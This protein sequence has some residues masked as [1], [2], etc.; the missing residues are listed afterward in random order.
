MLPNWPHSVDAVVKNVTQEFTPL[1]LIK[2]IVEL[3]VF[4]LAIKKYFKSRMDSEAAKIRQLGEDLESSNAQRRKLLDEMSELENEKRLILAA[5]PQQVLSKVRS[6]Y[7]SRNYSRVHAA[8]NDWF[9][10]DGEVISE[11][12]M[13]RAKWAIA[14]SAGD[15]R[16]D[17]LTAARAY[18]SAALTFSP[19]RQDSITL[20]AHT[21]QLLLQ[22]GG[23]T[24]PL[25]KVLEN[26]DER[27]K[28]Y[29]YNSGEVSK[30]QALIDRAAFCNQIGLHDISLQLLEVAVALLERNDG[31][32]HPRVL[33]TKVKLSQELV[34]VGRRPEAALIAAEVLRLCEAHPALGHTHPVTQSA[35]LTSL[36]AAHPLPN[37][38]LSSG[39]IWA[40]SGATEPD[41]RAII[42]RAT[43]LGSAESVPEIQRLNE[44][45]Q[46]K[47]TGS[48][49][50]AHS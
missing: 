33:D 1:F 36:V 46:R 48:A 7:S 40:P 31:S 30:A 34:S 32:N 9:N 27:L 13:W 47:P 20:T 38:T 42:S 37:G 11:L 41:V 18:A 6:D 49:S 26:L 29:F 23:T 22:A 19:G 44:K 43:G 15:L 14:H 5:S 8:V 50:D 2:N 21:D 17:A 16:L 3:G 24:A 28:S 35:R 12:L 4:F 39:F 45:L 10:A 25:S